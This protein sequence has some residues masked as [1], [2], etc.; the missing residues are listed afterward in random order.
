M[1]LMQKEIYAMSLVERLAIGIIMFEIIINVLANH[2]H[3][4]YAKS[5]LVRKQTSLATKVG[6]I[7]P[8]YLYE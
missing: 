5:L 2:K 6:A 1:L 8:T 3:H 7:I 4:Q